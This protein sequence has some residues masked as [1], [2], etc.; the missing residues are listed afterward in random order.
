MSKD[1]LKAKSM[2]RDGMKIEIDVPIPMDDGLTLRA[3]VY[4]PLE[5]GRYPA[6]ISY[7]P[8]AKGLS[9]QEAYKP[10]WDRMVSEHPDV[11][12]GSTNK[13]Q[14]WEALDP[15][16]W[17]PDGYVCVRVDSR[18]AGQ[19][20]GVL[21]VWSPR[22]TQDFYHCIEWA[23]AQPWCNGRV[24]LA[25]ISY[26]AMNQ[27]QVAALEPPHLMAI[28]PWEGASD[29]YREMGRHGG[30][31]STFTLGWFPRQVSTVQYGLGTRAAKSFTTGELVAGPV[32]LPDEELKRNRVEFGQ[33]IKKH[34]WMDKWN[35]DFNA[36]WSKVKTPMLSAGNWGGQG[37]HLRGNVEA[38]VQAAS[39]QKWLEVH[40]LEHWTHFYTDYGTKLQKQFFDHFLKGADNGWE[41]SPRVRL[42]IRHV[43]ST[44]VERFENEWPLA[45]TQWTKYYLDFN[46][47]ALSA[48]PLKTE[49]NI[50]VRG[51]RRRRHPFPASVRRDDRGYRAG[52]G[53]PLHIVDDDRRRSFPRPAPLRSRWRRGDVPGRARSEHP[54]HARVAARLASKARPGEV[55][56]VPA[57]PHARRIS[58]ACSRRGLRA[59]GR[60]L[61]DL[62]RRAQG[63]PDGADDPRQ[64]LRI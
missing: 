51:A 54:D 4:R 58:A 22:E 13:Y 57:L 21:D 17:V 41:K 60:D 63:I 2:V 19:S 56:A 30:I 11:L 52:D 59:P 61:A 25:G 37:L 7:G 49:Q 31:L 35:R 43:D 1:G 50:S 8:Y 62:H 64:G 38:F 12:A 45:R 34:G 55:P 24:G 26:Y 16:K 40:G 39:D 3:D 6:L 9:F 46:A 42:N 47:K 23:A 18:G 48:T 33:A 53:A 20:P 14:T 28:C 44:F 27:Y 10:Q 15:E 36:D 5:D 32:T 29:F